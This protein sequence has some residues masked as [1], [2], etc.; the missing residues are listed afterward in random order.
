M[1]K[2]LPIKTLSIPVSEARTDL[3]ALI[4]QVQSGARITLTSHGRPAARLVPVDPPPKP[5][6]VDEPDP[7]QRYGDLQSAVMEPWS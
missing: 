7:P 6:R 3:C 5:W 4:K 1:S 2:S